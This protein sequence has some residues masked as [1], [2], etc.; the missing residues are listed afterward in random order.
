MTIVYCCITSYCVNLSEGNGRVNLRIFILKSDAKPYNLDIRLRIFYPNLG[1]AE[2]L[3]YQGSINT[4]LLLSPRI[5]Y[6]KPVI[7]IPYL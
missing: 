7:I 5:P 6:A 2:S 3:V 1:C 4:Y